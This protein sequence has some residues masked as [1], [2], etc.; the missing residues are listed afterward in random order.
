MARR[1]H[2]ALA[3][4]DLN[5]DGLPDP[6]E[7]KPHANVV[8]VMFNSAGFHGSAIGVRRRA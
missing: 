1:E 7:A 6:A 4:G 8:T 5:Q 3:V 2:L